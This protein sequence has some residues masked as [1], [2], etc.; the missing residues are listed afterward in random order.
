MVYLFEGDDVPSGYAVLFEEAGE[1]LHA[2]GDLDAL[3]RVRREH[4]LRSLGV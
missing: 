2:G 3:R 4:L 1:D